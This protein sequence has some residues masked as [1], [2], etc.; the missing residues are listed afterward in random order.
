ME[1]PIQTCKHQTNI[2]TMDL[3]K[4]EAQV[5]ALEAALAE[6]N[7]KIDAL[8]RKARS[9]R[10][11]VEGFLRTKH[12]EYVLRFWRKEKEDRNTFEMLA[13]EHIRMQGVFWALGSL[14]ILEAENEV[15]K[16]E[17]VDWV[18]RCQDKET[19]GFGGNIGHDTNLINTQ[20]AVYALSQCDALDSIDF[21]QVAEYIRKR[22]QEDGCFSDEWSGENDLRYT[23]CA[24]FCLK[25]IDRLHVINTESC[26]NYVLSCRNDSDGGFGQ[27][28]AA[29]SHAAFTYCALGSLQVLGHNLK[30]YEA[31]DLAWW[32]CERQCDSGGLNGR[33]EKQADVC[34]SFWA[35]TSLKMLKRIDWI[36]QDLLCNFILQCQDEDAGGIADRPGNVSDL[37][38]TFF[39]LCGLELMHRIN[40]QVHISPVYAL[41]ITCLP[42]Q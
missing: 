26:K 16:S 32:L 18:M 22:Q 8:E 7:A 5:S 38:H 6:R 9:E 19:G 28:P 13:I 14:Q 4:L 40:S 3:A 1:I 27:M 11:D 33:P 39:G 15:D 31:D 29:E 25:M 35:L 37:F 10:G 2:G 12:L 41:P 20:F 21:D 23:C 30:P 34:Y 36:D 17:I 42:F 24:L